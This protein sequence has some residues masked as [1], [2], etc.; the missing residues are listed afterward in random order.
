MI[1]LTFGISF[2][3]IFLPFSF[4]F[5]FF[6]YI[7]SIQREVWEQTRK[8]FNFLLNLIKIYLLMWKF[9]VENHLTHTYFIFPRIFPIS[10][11]IFEINMF[12]FWRKSIIIHKVH[13]N[14]SSI[15]LKLIPVKEQR[16]N[17]IWKSLIVLFVQ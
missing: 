5:F 11:I 3:F 16:I 13:R 10:R 6:S 8:Y 17:L 9:K 12:S 14:W 15:T 2:L 4:C 7:D 1:L